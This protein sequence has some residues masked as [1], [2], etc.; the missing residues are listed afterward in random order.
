[1]E[2]EEKGCVYFFRH[3]GLSPIKIGYSTNESPLDRFMQF[4]TYAPYGSEIL[5]FIQTIDAKSLESKL[6]LKY[7][8]K[9]LSG[10]WF[11]I[12]EEEVENVINF[13]SNIE[14]IKLRNDFQIAWANMVQEKKKTF[15]EIINSIPANKKEKF[16]SFYLK[17]KKLNRSH[18]AAELSVSRKTIQNWIKEF[19]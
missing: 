13:Y 5:G 19:N 15:K 2:K 6:H 3:I 14:D 9:R 7:S 8:Q 11:E 4:K 18:M 1:M 12:T 16:K 10:E 17:N